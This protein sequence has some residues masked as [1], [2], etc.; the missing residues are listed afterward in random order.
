MSNIK[1]VIKQALKQKSN[2][3]VGE[4]YVNVSAF[5]GEKIDMKEFVKAYNE[6]KR[7]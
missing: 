4:L 2:F 6:V 7:I 5:M 1:K 3:A